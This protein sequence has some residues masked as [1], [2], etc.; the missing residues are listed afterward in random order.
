MV[1]GVYYK[2]DN[3]IACGGIFVVALCWLAFGLVG[4]VLAIKFN[5]N[6][7]KWWSKGEFTGH[8][9]FIMTGP[10]LFI[11]GLCCAI[12]FFIDPP[13]GK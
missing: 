13:N 7:Y 1:R 6:D 9:P 5:Q 8:V 2:G 10:G 11:H 12:L 4:Y 3:V